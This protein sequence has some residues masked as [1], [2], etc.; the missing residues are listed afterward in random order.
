MTMGSMF[1]SGLL[2]GILYDV[3]RVAAKKLKVSRWLLAILDLVYWLAATV[4]VFRLLY[5][6]NQGQVR[7]FVFLSLMIGI[8]CYFALFSRYV[9]RLI[10]LI[11]RVTKAIL[12][13]CKAAI[14][15]L[16]VKPIL[17]IYRLLVI[18]L[19]FLAALSIFFGKIVLQLLYPL[20]FITRPL[21][22]MLRKYWHTPAWIG[23]AAR[24]LKIWLKR[25]FELF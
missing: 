10:Y 21:F 16:I 5:L 25:I 20:W 19:G 9:I 22:R 15:V 6:S 2:L 11:I 24:K 13:F 7:I 4:L 18:I 12:R 14:D 1:G 17:A 23:R 3:Y 8:C